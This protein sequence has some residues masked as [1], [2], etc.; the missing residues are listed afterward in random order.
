MKNRRRTRF[1][2]KLHSKTMN[3]KNYT[4]IQPIAEEILH[5][6]NNLKTKTYQKKV[7]ASTNLNTFDFPLRA[8]R[9]PLNV[10]NKL[11][12]Y[13]QNIETANHSDIIQITNKINKAVRTYS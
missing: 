11:K 1:E 12:R 3:K 5:I 13:G 8:M 10:P 2:P 4:C 7:R 9:I 6:S